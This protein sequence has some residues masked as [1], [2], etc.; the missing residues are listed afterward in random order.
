MTSPEHAEPAKGG[1]YSSP[2]GDPRSRFSAKVADYDAARP[3]YPESL[4]ATL[5]AQCAD[6]ALAAGLCAGT[7]L[8]TQG[9]LHHGFRVVA[10]E[11]DATM[12]AACDR[13]LGAQ[14][15]YR[16]AD[17]SAEAIPVAD[18]SVDL[19]TAAQ[20]FHWFDVPRARAECLRVLKP[21]GVVALIW[22]DRV[23]G[24]PLQQE[25]DA[26]FAEHGG[27]LHSAQSDRAD[28]P[29][30]FGTN[31][32]TEQAWPHEHRLAEA[33][34]LSL[35]FSRSYMPKRSSLAAASVERKVRQLFRDWQ[36][37]GRV[38]VRYRTVAIFGRPV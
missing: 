12:R 17:G 11:P 7:G 1:R 3:D 4:F 10:V 28:V 31:A 2:G 20:S 15:G 38:V 6:A 8:L 18:A 27:A 13:R 9:L 32:P 19:I 36:L 23:C 16:S 30:F 25:L 33:G 14:P 26:V 34:L 22:N 24:D 5:R 29:R 37:E 35:V 21:A